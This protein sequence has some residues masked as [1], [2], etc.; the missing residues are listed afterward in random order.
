MVT[1]RDEGIRLPCVSA[2]TLTM[3]QVTLTW[4][5][6]VTPLRARETG[7]IERDREIVLEYDKAVKC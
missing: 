5:T 1:Q 4:P 3:P 6:G 2:D 7:K